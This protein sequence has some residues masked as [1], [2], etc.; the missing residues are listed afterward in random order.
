M[1]RLVRTDFATKE[2]NEAFYLN[3]EFDTLQNMFTYD[4]LKKYSVYLSRYETNDELYS[5]NLLSKKHLESNQFLVYIEDESFI[6]LF[7]HKTVYSAKINANFITDD[8]IKSILITKHIT[9]LSS[10]GD[11]DKFYYIVNSKYKSAVENILKHNTKNELGEIIAE[12]L[13]E[14]EELIKP[15]NPLDTVKTHISKSVFIVSFI[16]LL[17]WIIIFGLPILEKSF[18]NKESLTMLKREIKIE[19]RSIKRQEVL[20]KAATK[21]YENLTQCITKTEVQND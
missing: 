3:D 21:K 5:L 16:S 10:G 6:I 15:L 19:N 20:L 17:L 9:M 1:V 12:K 2:E 14:I 13:G 4:S 7:N 8:I 11:I 18:F